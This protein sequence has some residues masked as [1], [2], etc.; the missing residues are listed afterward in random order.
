LLPD[1]ERARLLAL[2]PPAYADVVA[3]HVTCDFG[4]DLTHPLPSATFGHVVGVA[5]D[6]ERVQALV[7]AV[8]ETLRRSDNRVFHCTWSLDRARKAKPVMS[9]TLIH[10]KGWLPV[11]WTKVALVPHRFAT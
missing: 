2:F 7:F 5:D 4:V 9:N 6:G 3:H 10:S 11:D 8:A 1:A